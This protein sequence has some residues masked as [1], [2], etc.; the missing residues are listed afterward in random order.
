MRELRRSYA[1]AAAALDKLERAA[2]ATEA[3]TPLLP[4]EEPPDEELRELLQLVCRCVCVPTRLTQ[5]LT[6]VPLE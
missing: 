4:A 2:G 5:L 1:A 3:D 6:L